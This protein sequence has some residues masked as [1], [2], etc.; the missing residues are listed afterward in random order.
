MFKLKKWFKWYNKDEDNIIYTLKSSLNYCQGAIEF[1]QEK[2]RKEFFGYDYDHEICYNFEN[3]LKD[4]IGTQKYND[5]YSF[6]S[7]LITDMYKSYSKSILDTNIIGSN[8]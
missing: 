6:I 5:N 4:I 8:I 2:G 1:Y 7:K 3:Y